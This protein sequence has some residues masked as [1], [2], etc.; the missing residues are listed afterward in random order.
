LSSFHG[1]QRWRAGC[2]RYVQ[3]VWLI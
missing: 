3:N 1:I 2:F